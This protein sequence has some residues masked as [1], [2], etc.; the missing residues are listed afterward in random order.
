MMWL[1]VG[2]GLDR[3]PQAAV[4][5]QTTGASEAEGASQAQGASQAEGA[6]Q[7]AQ[8]RRTARAQP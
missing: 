4:T 5:L 6:S 3:V 1:L 2:R 8:N 7:V